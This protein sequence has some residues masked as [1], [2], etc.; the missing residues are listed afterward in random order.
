MGSGKSILGKLIASRLSLLLV[1]LDDLIVEKAGKKIPQIFADD[2]EQ[3]FR[4]ME[5]DLLEQ[6]IRSD[7]NQVIATGGGVVL[8]VKN[9]RLIQEE[10]MV[11]WLDAPVEVL[12][13]RIAGD[14]NRPLLDN[15]HPLHKMKALAEERNA[16]YAEV[17]HLRINTDKLSDKEAVD[18]IIHFLSE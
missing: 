11:I 15:V 14:T 5:S 2:G 3:T 10:G 16:L 9:R 4:D 17:S 7:V 18:K 6:V 13:N 1:D 12:A 8:S